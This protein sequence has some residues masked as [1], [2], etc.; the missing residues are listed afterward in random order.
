M[1]KHSTIQAFSLKSEEVGPVRRVSGCRCMYCTCA[2]V[3]VYSDYRCRG[4]SMSIVFMC[5]GV[6]CKGSC[7]CSEVPWIGTMRKQNKERHKIAL[8]ITSCNE[9]IRNPFATSISD[10]IICNRQQIGRWCT[11]YKL[12]SNDAMWCVPATH[13]TKRRG[14]R[15]K[16]GLS[17]EQTLNSSRSPY[18]FRVC[19]LVLSTLTLCLH[20]RSVMIWFTLLMVVN[21]VVER[22]KLKTE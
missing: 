18:Q 19:V 20:K 1:P 7:I 2:R 3:H 6:C 14:S 11:R 17:P 5:V 4:Q 21:I 8:T 16:R 22:S 9:A 10:S 15:R 12:M 13:R